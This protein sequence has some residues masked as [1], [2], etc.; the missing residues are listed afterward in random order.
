MTDHTPSL[1]EMLVR[2]CAM[3]DARLREMSPADRDR[4]LQT[5]L[6]AARGSRRNFMLLCSM[7][8]SWAPVLRERLREGNQ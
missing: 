4:M 1:G 2:I 7:T 3:T 6:A 8:D 5:H